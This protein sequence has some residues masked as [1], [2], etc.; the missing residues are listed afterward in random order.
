MIVNACLTVMVPTSCYRVIVIMRG[1]PVVVIWVIVPD[2][3]GRAETT[4]RSIRPTNAVLKARAERTT[5][6]GETNQAEGRA[7]KVRAQPLGVSSSMC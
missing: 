7:P 6:R 1:R 2:V 3:R 4:P 5:L